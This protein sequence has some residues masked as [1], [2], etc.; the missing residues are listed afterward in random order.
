MKKGRI[1]ALILLGLLL[2]GCS[3]EALT[4]TD[5]NE[6]S[7]DVTPIGM[8]CKEV[9]FQKDKLIGT[10]VTITAY[11][12][13]STDLLGGGCTMRL[14]DQ[15]SVGSHPANVVAD[16][17]TNTDEQIKKIARGTKLNIKAFVS[18]Y[19]SGALH[20]LNPRILE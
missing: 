10:I 5:P 15:E 12:W 14:G 4:D 3:A 13:G 18:G 7:S 11:N 19:E 8:S 2:V 16:F 1:S 20:L 9:L 6:N 17:Y